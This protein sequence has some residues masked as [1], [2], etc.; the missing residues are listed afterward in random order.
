MA[1]V[2]D[3]C[4]AALVS[5]GAQPI[6][7]LSDSTDRARACASLWPIVRDD[8]LRDHPWNCAIK[9][10]QLAAL[11]DAPAYDYAY[12]F[13]LPADF[14]RVVSVGAD[15]YE[16]DHKIEGGKILADS[17][18]L[19]LRYV[20]RNE[21]A[22]TYDSQLTQAM[23]LAMS[24]RLAYAI[25]QSSGMESQRADMYARHMQRARAIDGQDD[26]PQTLGDSPLIASRFSRA[27]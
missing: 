18:P 24:A 12:Q 3:I 14:L 10:T 4:S 9:R 17:S 11:S 22:E 8:V 1:S 5:L 6:S 16:E 19:K 13:V 20:Y 26:P 27:F 23:V 21:A 7:S 15:G 2:V 25:T